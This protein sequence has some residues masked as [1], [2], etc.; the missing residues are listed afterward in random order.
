M[1][2]EHVRNSLSLVVTLQVDEVV[3]GQTVEARALS[4]L[5]QAFVG[6][7]VRS[8]EIVAHEEGESIAQ[9]I[10]FL[11][12]VRMDEALICLGCI[13]EFIVGVVNLGHGLICLEKHVLR[14]A[15]NLLQLIQLV[16]SHRGACR[17]VRT[18]ILQI[19]LIAVGVEVDGLFIELASCTYVFL[20]Q[21][22]VA[23]Q[24]RNARVFLI[25][26]LGLFDKLSRFFCLSCL[27]I[28]LGQCQNQVYILFV[29]AFHQ[30]FSH[31]PCT[32]GIGLYHFLYLI[33]AGLPIRLGLRGN[34]ASKQQAYAT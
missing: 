1:V 8:L 34:H 17:F 14:N 12:N 26:L 13:R 24:Q 33:N 19:S 15:C 27:Q 3:H 18:G 20:S 22:D 4:V 31:I 28:N 30:V 7:L 23:F 21:S 10:A 32:F 11:G 5:L 9:D 2:E 29:F 6:N 16:D 25:S